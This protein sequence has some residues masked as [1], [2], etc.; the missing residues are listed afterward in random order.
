M[1]GKQSGPGPRKRH[2]ARNVEPKHH[3]TYASEAKP[4]GAQVCDTCG[5]VQVAGR[6]SR[7]EPPVDA[8]RGVL[9]P[10]C[11]RT[12]DRHPAGTIRVP[13]RLLAPRDEIV[14]LIRHTEQAEAETHP[15]ERIMAIDD[16]G[17]G[18]LVTT[19]GLHLARRIADQ[20]ARRLH[21]KPSLHY[22]EENEVR[23]AWEG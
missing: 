6:W 20:L 4:A 23:V 22:G 21:T 2:R 13:A 19:T 10:A 18:I 7:A 5:L 1:S 3:D 14:R 15:L 11:Q 12:R 17:D 9:C 16:D 8:V